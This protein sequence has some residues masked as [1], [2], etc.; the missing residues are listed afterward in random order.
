MIEE[1]QREGR[2]PSAG[3]EFLR[4]Q[5]A[6][7]GT[8]VPMTTDIVGAPR[9]RPDAPTKVRGATRYAADRPMRGLLHARLVLAPRA[10][11]RVVSIERD[12][13]LGAPGRGGGLHGRR[14]AAD[15]QRAAIGSAGR[16]PARRSCSP[17][18]RSHS[19]SAAHPRRPRT[20]S[21]WSRSASR[22]CPTVVDAEAA[23]RP[24]RRI[25]RVDL[26]AEGDRTGSM[27]A[28]THAGVGGGGDESI[29]AEVLSE[30][31]TGRYRYREGDALGALGRS[32]VTR[33]GRV[34]DRVGPPGL[35]RAAG[36]HRLDRR[37]R[38]ARDRDIDAVAFR[39]TQRGREGAGP[40]AA[41]GARGGDAARR[42]LRRQVAAV[43]HAGRR[44][45]V[46]APAPRPTRRHALGGL[47]GREPGPGHGHDHPGQ[48]RCRGPVHPARGADRGR[49]RRVRGG[50]RASRSPAS[51]SPGRTRGPRST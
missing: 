7:V 29:D 19:W 30:N 21:S 36:V 31:V 26:A 11:A 1:A 38:H 2:R 16:S 10:H 50:E 32:A 6:L 9:P 25:A 44:G 12:A 20:A 13:A 33:E 48:R 45:R 22:R 17:A 41:P 49:R 8:S 35:P 14:P 27:D 23:M 28:Q 34:L 47:R 46:E 18:S 51:S 15:G 43:R 42:R 24:A 5:R 37:R 39:R 40:A 3:A 4:G